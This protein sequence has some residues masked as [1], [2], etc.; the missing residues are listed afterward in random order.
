MSEAE[1]AYRMLCAWVLHPGR[2]MASHSAWAKLNA[3]MDDVWKRL[4]WAERLRCAAIH[5]PAPISS[6]EDTP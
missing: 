6:D 4:S 2:D 1:T 3:R 5:V